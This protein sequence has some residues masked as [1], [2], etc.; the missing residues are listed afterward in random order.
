[1]NESNGLNQL[2][3]AHYLRAFVHL[4]ARTGIETTEN[5]LRRAYSLV[6]DK[7]SSDMAQGIA[8]EL[9]LH[10]QLMHVGWDSVAQLKGAF[11]AM[12][13]VRDGS[14][15]IAEGLVEDAPEGPVLLA[16]DADAGSDDVDIALDRQRFERLCTGDF[17]LLKRHYHIADTLQP[18]SMRWIVSQLLLERGLLRDIGIASIIVTLFTLLPPVLSMIVLDRVMVNHSYSTLAVMCGAVALLIIFEM[19]TSYIRRLFMEVMATR[20]DGRLGLYLLDRLLS[21]PLDFFERNPTGLIQSKLGKIYQIRNFLTGKL[22]QTGLDMIVVAIVIPIL[23]VLNWA[24]TLAILAL[25]LALALIVYFYADVVGRRVKDMVAAEQRKNTYLVETIYGIK[26]IKSLA[27]EGRRR[28]EWDLRVAQSVEARYELGRTTNIPQTLSV[29]F[30]RLIFAGVFLMGA[31]LTLIDPNAFQA[32]TLMAFIML[33]NRATQ[34]I[35]QL[36]QLMQDF[37]EIR[38]AINEVGSV[39]NATPELTR[40][41]TGLRQPIAGN[42]S[43]SDVSFRYAPGAPLALEGVNLEVPTGTILGIMGRSGSGKT[44][45]TRLLQGLNGH[46]EG[47]VKID[48]MDLREIDLQH[49]RT[50]IGV[51][52]QEN[53]LFSGTIRENIGIAKPHATFSEIVRVAQ[54][55]G[56]EEFIER[57]PKGYDTY[58]S[59]GAANLSGGQRQRLAIARALILDPPILI[60]DEATSALDAESEAIINANLMRI[61]QGRTII[62][63]SHRLAMLVNADNIL[64]MERGQVDDI[65]T[66]DELLHRNEIYKHMW[67]TQNRSNEVNPV[68]RITI[69]HHQ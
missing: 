8:H 22:L 2:H 60:L 38:E 59:E 9:G 64:V 17:V 49:L 36:A 67:H 14:F 27:I 35:V 39:V 57:L 44:T 63:V 48:G 4:A 10:V 28:S 25:A 1:M 50:S 33:G 41:G 29:P 42:L 13:M 16:R 69:A 24:L 43:F 40:I 32:G 62:C 31:Y 20:I 34:P 30:E 68:A 23:F 55:A 56:A 45:I 7:L 52:A 65:G 15:L 54:L 66:H 6:D 12:L 5:E 47:I 19:I 3:S 53:F 21:L 46:Y 18:F 58:L 37:G 26:T 51:V 61:A 11:P